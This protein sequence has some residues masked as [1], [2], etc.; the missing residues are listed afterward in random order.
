MFH[1][2][3]PVNGRF[4]SSLAHCRRVGVLRSIAALKRVSLSLGLRRARRLRDMIL[5]IVLDQIYGGAVV[6][7]FMLRGGDAADGPR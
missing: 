4:V 1:G 6:V 7:G 2:E 3:L 5:A